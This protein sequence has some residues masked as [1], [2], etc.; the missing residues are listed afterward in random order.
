[1]NAIA[2]WVERRLLPGIGQFESTNEQIKQRRT[3]MKPNVTWIHFL[4]G[5]MQTIF[6]LKMSNLQ[7]RY[8]GKGIAAAILGGGPS[9]PN[10][11]ARLPMPCL[12]IAVNYHAMKF[13]RPAFI[14][15]NDQP[16]GD[17][18]LL[19]AFQDRTV[20]KVSPDPTSDIKFDVPVWT[21]FYSS[22]TAA[23][24][25]LWMGCDPVILCGMDCYQGDVK[26]C[27]P[28]T[29]DQPSYHYPLDDHIRP[30]VEDGRNLLPNVERL[31]VMSGPLVNIFGQY[32]EKNS[33]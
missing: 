6:M 4:L 15:Y 20:I 8:E 10:D 12:L 30:W 1:M 23:W 18:E 5:G 26:Y 31:K 24:F 29:T 11:L 33:I 17:P 21:G 3:G 13:C 28:Y 19:K 32:H 7:S 14:V 22:N 2:R 27:H 9:L 25:A 16:E